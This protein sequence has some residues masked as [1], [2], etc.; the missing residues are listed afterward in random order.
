MANDY[1]DHDED[2]GLDPKIRHGRD[3]WSRPRC[4]NCQGVLFQ[5]MIAD[6]CL[7]CDYGQAY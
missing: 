1:D 2:G 4:P 3:R 6:V 7:K 5:N